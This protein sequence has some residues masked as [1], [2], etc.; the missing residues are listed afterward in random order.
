MSDTATRKIPIRDL[1]HA[2]RDEIQSIAAKFRAENVRVFGSVSRNQDTVGSDVDL[3]V[4]FLP[5]A[6][7]YDMMGLEIAIE[8]LLGVHVDIASDD[9]LEEAARAQI[10]SEAVAL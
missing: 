6:T 3:L 9:G 4:T 2:R 7:V 1:L 10:L 5:G 8:N